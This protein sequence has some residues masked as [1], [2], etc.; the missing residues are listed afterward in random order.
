VAAGRGMDAGKRLRS[1]FQNLLWDYLLGISTR[2]IHG[3]AAPGTG[4][5]MTLPY[6]ATFAIL[7]RLSLTPLDTLLDIGCGKGRV[8]CCAS[9]FAPL[10]VIGVENSSALC[11]IAERN[12]ARLR[13][14]KAPI[15]VANASAQEFDYRGVDVLYFYN[16]LAPPILDEVLA[17]IEDSLRDEGRPI[18]FVYAN[19]V[20]ERTL[21]SR[22][23]LEQ[24]DELHPDQDDRIAVRVSFWKSKVG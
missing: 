9:L 8:I 1:R 22:S 20:H 15:I 5:Y 11:A 7:R 12:V 6:A 23:W 19:P 2:G 4:R 3:A 18:R 17:R 21:E 16:S 10:R 24:Y 13:R 14:R